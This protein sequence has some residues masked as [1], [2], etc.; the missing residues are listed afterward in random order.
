MTETINGRAYVIE[1][2]P[3]AP[4]RWRAQLA[5]RGGTA[6]M[7]FYGTSPAEAA[8]QLTKWLTRVSGTSKAGAGQATE[9]KGLVDQTGVEPVT[10]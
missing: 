9:G 7:P 6:L 5:R 10:S 2:R 8:E 4:D 3:V 1:V